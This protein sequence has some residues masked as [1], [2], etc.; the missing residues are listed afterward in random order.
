MR[1]R[2]R[3]LNA[4][5]LTVCLGLAGWTASFAQ[6]SGPLTPR[7]PRRAP[8][9]TVAKPEKP[10]ELPPIQTRQRQES[11]Q[12]MALFT[13]ETN[14]V[15]V[16]VAV[17]DDQGRFIPKI[18][19]GN[20]MVMEDDVPQQ[21]QSF[22]VSQA[23]MTVALLIEFNAR[24]Q[25]H[26]TETWYQTLAAAYGFTETLRPED[27]VAVIAYDLRPEILSDF[28]K[29]SPRDLPGVATAS[30]DGILRGEPVRRTGGYLRAHERHRRPQ[31]HRIDLDRSGY[32]QQA[33][34]RASPPH[35]ARCRA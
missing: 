13:T 12:D 14:V 10:E 15:T 19:Q 7:G 34:L 25:R 31:I 17:L 1:S 9:P 6:R 24:H 4:L 2:H 3:L 18:P 29:G 32:L 20:F 33:E 8:G 26:W 23:P 11:P 28:H 27:W 5:V 35:R 21:I 16:D 22:G 30:H